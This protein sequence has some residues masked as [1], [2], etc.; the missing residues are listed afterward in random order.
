MVTRIPQASAPRRRLLVGIIVFLAALALAFTALSGFFIDVLWFR[1]VGY[2]Q[3]FWSIL[4][5]KFTLG[6]LFGIAFFLLLYANLWIV[7]RV[8]PRYQPLT[9]EQEIIERYRLQFEPYAWWLIP[10]FAAVIAF[11]VGL[12]VTGQWRTFLVWRNSGGV[13]FGVTEPQFGRDAA[14]YVFSLP[15]LEFVQGWLFSAL[16]GV[17]LISAVAH[18]LWGGIRPN[19]P[20]FAEK[21]SPQVKAHL[22]VLLG[23][24]MLSK[25]WGYYLGQ[26]DLLTSRRGVVAGASYTDVN[27]HLPALR[28]LVFIALVCAILFLVNIRMRGWALPVIAVG[29]LVLVSIA[30]GAAYP[31]FVQRFSVNPQ[32]LQ[33]E[34]PFI[35]RN[36]EATRAAFRLDAI[37]S[38]TAPLSGTVSQDDVEANEQTIRNIRLWRPSILID[39]YAALQRIRSYYDFHDIDVD[40]YMIEGETRLV[41]VSAREIAQSEIP[42]GGS[43]QNRHLVYT[44]GFGAVAS[45]VNTSTSEG[46]PLFTLRDIPPVGEPLLEDDGRRVYYG[47]DE[48]VSFVVVDT[49][50]D[51]L[52]YQGTP[53]DDQEQVTRNYQG[54]GGIPIGGLFQRALFAWRYR[55][56]NLLI[57]S[58][59]EGDSRIMIYRDIHERVPKAAPFLQFD[60][61]P[62]A[63]I[64]DGRLVWIWDAY[65]TTN[66]YPYSEP[67]A[68]DEVATQPDADVAAF[69]SLSGEA[70]YIRNSV[71]VVVDAYNGTIDYYVVDE[72]DPIIQV[73]RSAFPDLFT[74]MSEATP[75]LLAHFRYPENLFQVQ[76]WQFTRYHVTD[77]TVFYGRQ[78]FWEFPGDPAAAPV[79]A[80]EVTAAAVGPMRPYYVLMRLP[81]EQVETFSLILPFTPVARQNMIAWLAAKSDPGEGYGQMISYEFPSGRNVDGPT[82]V[83]ARINADSQ[84]AAERTLLGQGGSEIRF[85]DFLVVPIEESLLYVQP[86][87]VQSD[88]PN[89]IPE[90]RRVVVVNGPDI[91]IGSTLGEAL[92]DALGDA[93]PTPTPTP[94][95]GDGG[96]EPPPTGTV[97]E[98]VQALLDEAANHFALADAALRDGDLATYQREVELAQA[99]IDEAQ[100]LLGGQAEMSPSPSP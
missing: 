25:A 10:L 38:R 74:P 26:F 79:D 55:D 8:T 4:G 28:I 72:R 75:D 93:V 45:Q 1:E 66:E 7:R 36:I 31:S 61:D 97:D 41:M 17:L 86:V 53:E 27:A 21:V 73:W 42:G 92:D 88:Q 48:D 15:W 80:G 89:A 77:P 34:R 18:Y 16:V 85:G 22:S 84:F 90:L 60:A 67:L 59:I 13:T 98:Q 11:F 46:Q 63:A 35:E 95:D 3:V 56:V 83:F 29:L 39:N 24:I 9:P 51:E 69:P 76:A 99:A 62:Y 14:F 49:A 58:L 5:T 64:V 23:L 37:E 78:D 12:G 32:E 54:S 30:A 82:Q 6:L 20:A 43:W 52:D 68:L 91:G 70:N 96:G 2:S 81:G 50:A 19:A 33:R 65:T 40:R 87:Y 71:K 57:S 47:E 94:P 44:H 100:A